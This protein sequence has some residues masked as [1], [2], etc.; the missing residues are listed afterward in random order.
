MTKST[1]W[2]AS[3]PQ[4]KSRAAI[5][6]DLRSSVSSP[7]SVFDILVIGGGA[8][9][10]GI[11]LDAVTRGLKVAL[12]EREDFASGTS[13][14]STKL[15]HGGVRYLE[16][17]VLQ[18]D[19]EQYK[20]VREALRERDTFLQMAPHLTRWLPIMLPVKHWWELP[21]LWIGTKFYDLIAGSST[22]P[23]S[24]YLSK[25]EAMLKFP[26]L[27]A[28]QMST[29]LVYHDGLQDDARMNVALA[30]TAASYG[31][32]ITNYAEVLSLGK[33]DQGRVDGVIVKDLLATDSDHEQFPIKAKC[34]IN[35]TG[36]FCDAIRKLDD[37]LCDNIVVPSKGVHIA[38]PAHC[39]PPGM[40]M[41]DAHSPDGRVVFLLPWQGRT[42]AGTTDKPCDVD[43]LMEPDEDD[44]QWILDQVNS[45]LDNSLRL[46]R[47]DVLSVWAG[48]RPL[49]KDP[50][51]ATSQDIV[52]HHLI[53]KSKSGLLT[54][55][56][57]KWTTFRQMAEDAVDAAMESIAPIGVRCVS[58]R[59]QAVGAKGWSETVSTM[60]MQEF[61][62]DSDVAG[63]LSDS[64]GDQAWQVLKLCEVS[65]QRD[66]QTRLSPLHPYLTGEV[67][68]AVRYEYAQHATDVLARRTRLAYI[69]AKEAINV[70]PLV[71][72]IMAEELTWDDGRKALKHQN[73]L[74]R[75]EKM[76]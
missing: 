61:D 48:I 65:S 67:R 45:Y 31:A 12:V 63:H 17:A 4:I 43:P 52:R 19:I 51:A 16:K 7:D 58:A 76:I 40:G 21:Y 55:S 3:P 23:S 9:G 73:A 34:V 11:A 1:D 18:L 72:D 69:D 28:S 6:E 68:Y 42:I 27:D 74:K 62:L 15:V 20:L 24:Y 29:A 56:G 44:V 22:A 41:I 5:M 33:N 10:T 57:G 39:T 32:S 38:L 8:T 2:K 14:Q 54:V 25:K 35:A 60:L 37:Q 30:V 71:I 13:S 59:I 46:A 70:L 66:R 64:Y 36:P 47:Q 26:Q 50:S 53:N 75:L 49:V